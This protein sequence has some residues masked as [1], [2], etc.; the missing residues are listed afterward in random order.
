MAQE[1]RNLLEVLKAE[2]KFLESGGYRNTARA[3]WRPHFIFQD[4]PTCLNFDPMEP[5]RPCSDCVLSRVMPEEVRD[6]A[7]ACRYIPLN[8]R[9][10][11]M[12]SLYRSA[13]SRELE[14][15]VATWLK[16]TILRLEQEAEAKR[17]AS[18]NPAVQA[19]A[20]AATGEG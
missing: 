11:T 3:P 19:L 15:A 13:S 10:E 18:E 2:L 7:V 5:P 1:N 17:R 20:K 14:A 4:S 9:G 12:D 6:R 16:A 8:E